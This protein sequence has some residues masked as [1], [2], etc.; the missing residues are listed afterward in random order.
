MII[1]LMPNSFGTYKSFYVSIRDHCH[2]LCLLEWFYG[3]LLGKGWA[4]QGDK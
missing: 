3:Y 2:Y 4:T 1:H